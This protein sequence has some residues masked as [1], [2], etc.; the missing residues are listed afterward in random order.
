MRKEC[1]SFNVPWSFT[2]PVYRIEARRVLVTAAIKSC[3]DTSRVTDMKFMFEDTN[4]LSHANKLFIRCAWQ[5]NSAFVSAGYDGPGW[6][7][8]SCSPGYDYSLDDDDDG[9]TYSYG[10][11][12]SP[13][14]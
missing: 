2:D 6:V 5:G 9:F 7:S 13:S 11:S 12:S 1:H 10:T 4:S 8:G 3:V 14:F